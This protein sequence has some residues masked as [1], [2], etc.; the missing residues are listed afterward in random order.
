MTLY[1]AATLK[2]NIKFSDKYADFMLHIV[3]IHKAPNSEEGVRG[4]LVIKFFQNAHTLHYIH[5]H[6]NTNTQSDFPTFVTS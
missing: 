2:I 1:T 5:T 6:I 4:H 3:T